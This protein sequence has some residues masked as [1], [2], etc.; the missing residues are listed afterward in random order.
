MQII[1]AMILEFLKTYESQINGRFDASTLIRGKKDQA[2]LQGGAKIKFQ[3]HKLYADMEKFNASQE[4]SDRDIERAMI[5]MEGVKI[6]GF[7]SPDLFE[8]LLAP[9]LDRL[10]DPAQDLIQDVFQQL[11]GLSHMII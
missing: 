10:K 9:L 8:Y 6:S 1:W 11:E 4:Y 3:F 7:P 2:K 5:Q